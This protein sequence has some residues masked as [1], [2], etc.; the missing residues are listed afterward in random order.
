LVVSQEELK[1]FVV[2]IMPRVMVLV[3]TAAGLAA[4]SVPHPGFARP[5]FPAF[6]AWSW[7]SHGDAAASDCQGQGEFP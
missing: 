7:L 1:Y 4:W 3:V 6:K 2:F 5:T